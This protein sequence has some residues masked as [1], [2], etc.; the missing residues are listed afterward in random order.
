[1]SK[2]TDKQIEDAFAEI[3]ADFVGRGNEYG[4]EILDGCENQWAET[5]QLSDGQLEWLERQLNGNWRQASKQQSLEPV[6]AGTTRER[7]GSSHSA[8]ATSHAGDGSLDA[9]IREKLA[10]Q[11]EVVVDLAQLDELDAA[12]DDL[13]QTIKALRDCKRPAKAP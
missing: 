3:R 6:Q 13:K 9:M 4:L 1:M 5:G 12:V 8:E 2:L 7:G 11:G 10:E